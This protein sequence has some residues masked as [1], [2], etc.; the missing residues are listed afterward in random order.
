MN[1]FNSYIALTMAPL[2]LATALSAQST[3][4][5]LHKQEKATIQSIDQLATE[6]S[7]DVATAVSQIDFETRTLDTEKLIALSVEQHLSPVIHRTGAIAQEFGQL[8]WEQ[9][10]ESDMNRILGFQK[11]KIIE[12]IYPVTNRQTISIDNQY[13][14]ITI[15][16]WTRNEVKVTVKVRTAENSE[17]QAQ[18]ALDRV[19]IDQSKS[20]DNISFKTHIDSGN[21]NW[22]SLLTS[23]AADRALRIDYD[24]YL[25]KGNDLALAN[26]YGA[27]ELADRE[28]NVALSVS[29]GS[30]RAGHLNG[31]DN[32]L[33]ITYSKA[34]LEYLNE[35]DIAVRYGGFTLSEAE[36]L[37]LSLSYTSGSE[38]GKVNREADISLRYSGGFKMGLGPDI[39]KANVAAS[40]SNVSIEPVTDAA[41]NFNVAISY[42]GFDYDR[43]RINISSSSENNTS[44]SYSGYWNKATGNAV[45]VSSRYGAVSLK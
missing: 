10:W 26:R 33:L 44:K 15:H 32:S 19:R 2:L 12:K 24:V 21:S 40:Y 31:Q 3:R 38:I 7:I 22:W 30:L 23:G 9:P 42:G 39:Q 17:R 36:K 14:K 8:N 18:E 1:R 25:P 35:G 29:Y 5:R 28:G 34:E 43:S 11:E 13:G 6:L 27:I 16:N 41:F 37:T 20:E 4:Q 45:S